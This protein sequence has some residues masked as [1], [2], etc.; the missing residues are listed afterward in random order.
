MAVTNE[1]DIQIQASSDKASKS[2]D[3]LITKLNQVN[4]AL[5]GL[6]VERIN[7]I[8]NSISGIKGARINMSS[9]GGGNVTVSNNR[10]A[11]NSFNELLSAVTRTNRGMLGFRGTMVKLA[12]TWGTFYAA[13]YPAIR[14]IKLIGSKVGDAMDYT[15]TFN[16]FKV[17]MNKIGHDAGD[18]FTEGFYSQIKNLDKKMTGSSQSFS[19]SI[20]R[21]PII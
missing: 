19:V 3:T 6:N 5:N 15:E 8:T 21:L 20:R 12:A 1:L 10:Q 11:T 9:G 4:T 7:Q 16:Y 14:L 18:E 2:L 17:T 13:M